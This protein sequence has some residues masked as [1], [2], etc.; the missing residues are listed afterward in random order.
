MNLF[1]VLSQSV[2]I[3]EVRIIKTGL[4][5]CSL[6]L[7]SPTQTIACSRQVEY[8]NNTYTLNNAYAISTK[9]AKST[10][11]YDLGIIL[12]ARSCKPLVTQLAS[13]LDTVL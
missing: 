8:S 11:L 13:N 2:Q 5:L 6:S 7:S 12:K 4:Y 3:M 9:L 1:I 10:A